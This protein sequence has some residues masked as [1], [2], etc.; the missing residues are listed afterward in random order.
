ADFKLEISEAVPDPMA[1]ALQSAAGLFLLSGESLIRGCLIPVENEKFLLV[2]VLHHI[3]TDKY[4][5]ELLVREVFSHYEAAVGNRL[6]QLPPP[7]L[8]YGDFSRWQQQLPGDIYSSLLFYW[9]RRLHGHL[10]ALEL[11][12]DHPRAAV[13]IF[14][15]ATQPF[16][17]SH[18][19][20]RRIRTLGRET[21]TGC[22]S[23]LLAAFKVLLHRYSGQDEIV[24]GTSTRNR[25]QQGAENIL[26]PLANLLVLRSCFNGETGFQKMLKGVNKTIADAFAYGEMPFDKLVLELAPRKDMSRTA[27]FDVLFQYEE[28]PFRRLQSGDLSV[29]I[30][31]TNRGWGKYDLDML[32]QSTPDNPISGILT[33]NSDYYEASTIAR[34]ID[35]YRVVLGDIAENMNRSVAELSIITREEKR[36][37]LTGW[38]DTHAGYPRQ[39]TIHRLFEQTV[40]TASHLPAVIY[41]DVEL[42]Y[43]EL[44]RRANRLARCLKNDFQVRPGDLVGI[45]VERSEK[46]I[47]GLLGILKAGAAYIPIDPN[48]PEK[49]VNYILKDSQCRLLLCDDKTGENA[50][51]RFDGTVMDITPILE[52]QGPGDENLLD[53][54]VTPT[55]TAYVIYT[56]G[57]T[58]RPK[59]CMI[60]HENLVR[61]LINDSRPFHFDR[62]DTWIM[63]HS[64]CF[65]FSVWEMYGALLNGGKLI[66]PSW[67]AVRDV[68][69]FPALVK[70]HGI[71]VLNQTPG[72]F[73]RF[74]AEEKKSAVKELSRH[75]R[76]VIFGGDKLEPDYLKEWVE[77][78]PLQDIRLVNMYGIT[79]TTVHVS[80]YPLTAD[81]VHAPY[82]ISP[83]GG[84]LPETTVYLMDEALNLQPV[85]VKG[86]FY[87]GGTGLARGYLNNPDLTAQRFIENPYLEGELMYKTGD[88]GKRSA[89]GN[90][91]YLGRVDG[92]VKIRG[93]RIELGEIENGLLSHPGIKEAVVRAGK[94]KDGNNYLAAYFTTSEELEINI[95]REFLKDIL[96]GYMVPAYFVQMEKFPLTA[97]GKIDKKNLPEPEGYISTGDSYQAPRSPVEELLADVWQEVLGAKKIGI[98]DDFFEL[99]GHSLKAGIMTSRI[100]KELNVDIPL[101]EIFVKPTIKE[102]SGYIINVRRQLGD[103]YSAIE[104][105]EQKE[106][107]PLSSGQRRLFIVYRVEKESIAYNVPAAFHVKGKLDRKTFEKTVRKLID[108]HE[109]LRTSFHMINNQPAQIKHNRVNFNVE[110]FIRDGRAPETIM[111]NYIRPFDLSRAPLLRVGMITSEEDNGILILDVHHILSDALS[112]AVLIRDF[113]KL[114]TGE[115][116]PELPIQYK[117]FSEWQN[118][119][120][121][122]GKIMNQE[123]Y[124]VER[125]S[126]SVPSLNMPTDYP[127][128]A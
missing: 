102:L 39:T 67:D 68:P 101:K 50:A 63:A 31:E 17:L 53:I 74:I 65:D 103:N 119:L 78:Y 32:I 123:K 108:R 112:N 37:L 98:N 58:G 4:S 40:E 71:T 96:P 82:P 72:A 1:H 44:N 94:D 121:T 64:F 86:E 55:D 91:E 69:G 26:G 19:L 15:E 107:Y 51:R 128:P 95:L 3:I 104:A 89:D 60:S 92:Q 57:T 2:L 45:M 8:Q 22:F 35:H 28:N 70:K 93:Y 33:Y 41:E 43:R 79:E 11:P 56:S 125:F 80:W 110:Y 124:W 126:G 66:V 75:L 42:S 25:A 88:I 52:K 9:K 30:V 105:A 116:L 120:L 115:E 118:K 99:G 117:D 34:I 87:V 113:I 59:G 36:Q 7:P 73:Y 20:S 61:L 100:H 38:N 13:H 5:L 29:D 83:I 47:A 6:S 21:G 122:S 77:M 48:Y 46:M 106:Y 90:I 18:D 10:Q 109:S 81:D 62:N 127:R 111:K 24:V 12:G 23:L 54:N 84:P 16:T 14:T 49:R 114:Y 85:G 27:L 97:N 76:I